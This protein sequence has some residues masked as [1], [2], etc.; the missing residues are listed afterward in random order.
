M[1]IS[2]NARIKSITGVMAMAVKKPTKTKNK[3]GGA[4]AKKSKRRDKKNP[5]K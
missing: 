2:Y 1:N 3:L 4:P 5:C